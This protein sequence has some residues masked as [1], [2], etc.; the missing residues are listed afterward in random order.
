MSGEMH[1]RLTAD[2]PQ[3]KL[4][5]LEH[6]AL[7][8]KSTAKPVSIQIYSNKLFVLIGNETRI[9]NAKVLEQS[10]G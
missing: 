2:G 5:E 4:F 8:S 6:K 7:I 1:R 3:E 9:P 10:A